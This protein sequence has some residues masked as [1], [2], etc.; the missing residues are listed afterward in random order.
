MFQASVRALASD[1]R[2]ARHSR[3]RRPAGVMAV[4]T[5]FCSRERNAAAARLARGVGAGTSRRR[6]PRDRRPPLGAQCGV[7]AGAGADP[8]VAARKR[9]PAR[10]PA[11]P[12]FRRHRARVRD[13][14]HGAADRRRAAAGRGRRRLEFR[15]NESC[16]ERATLDQ[17]WDYALD[18]KNFRAASHPRPIVPVVVATGAQARRDAPLPG[19]DFAPDGVAR[20]IGVAAAALPALLAR[21]VRRTAASR[22]AENGPRWAATWIAAASA[23]QP[24]TPAGAVRRGPSPG[25]PAASHSSGKELTSPSGRW[26]AR[27]PPGIVDG[28]SWVARSGS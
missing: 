24:A 9:D 7:R 25:W 28:T 14:A 17:V 20:P 18:L 3:V 27:L 12:R 22:V 23:R 15:V 21:V 16:F 11:R 2:G 4:C 13:P 6:L 19:L 10:E 5:L 8:D 26:T 1:C